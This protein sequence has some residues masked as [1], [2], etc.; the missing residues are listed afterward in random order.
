MIRCEDSMRSQR[1]NGNNRPLRN[2]IRSSNCAISLFFLE[3]DANLRWLFYSSMKRDALTQ[4][5]Y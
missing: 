1:T 3:L 2:V 4:H 5:P